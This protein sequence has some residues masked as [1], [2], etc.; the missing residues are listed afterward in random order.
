MTDT[1]AI[2]DIS[3]PV[4]PVQIGHLPNHTPDFPVKYR[5]VKVYRDHAFVIADQFSDHGLQVFDLTAV[6][7][8]IT[9]PV[10]FT[11]KWQISR[12]K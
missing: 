4:N 5:D 10:V 11:E 8:V 6:R 9:P 2:I 7:D 12:T 3:D 1:L